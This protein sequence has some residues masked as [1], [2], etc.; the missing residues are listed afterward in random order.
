ML[1]G[2]KLDRKPVYVV[3][4]D[5][6]YDILGPLT[7]R[8]ARLVSIIKNAGGVSDSVEMGVYEFNVRRKG[9]KQIASLIRVEDHD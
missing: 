9:L 6:R 7:R 8:S 1:L 2:F 4:T 5:N 3:V